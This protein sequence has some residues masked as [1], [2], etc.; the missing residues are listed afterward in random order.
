V[1]DRN[2][3]SMYIMSPAGKV[4]K[5]FGRNGPGPGE[6]VGAFF[7]Y[8][9][10]KEI[11]VIEGNGN[12]SAFNTDGTFIRRFRFGM[13]VSKGEPYRS[14][15][16]QNAMFVHNGWPKDVPPTAGKPN[17]SPV[18]VWVSA[19]DSSS[20]H[21]IA[22]VKGAERFEYGSM[23]LGHDTRLA[24]GN[25][26]VYVAEGETYE[27]KVFTLDG[28]PL[29]SITKSVKP[30]A[31]TK[32]DITDDIDRLLQMVG[33]SVAKKMRKQVEANYEAAPLPK[34]LPPYRELLVDIDQNLWVRDYA[35]SGTTNVIWTVF[36]RTGKQ[37][38]EL[39]LPNTL[40]VF[41]IGKDYVLGRYIEANADLPEVRMYQ[42]NRR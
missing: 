13:G 3:Y 33:P 32:Q 14:A 17:R 7:T 19:G 37:L 36:D 8:R 4:L 21:M 39:A 38:T 18:P 12:I 11:F 5:K 40:E 2:D 41:E 23:P 9:C 16:N 6:M 22:T 27:I 24:L 15:C 29:P 30:V 42:L 31:V 28:K 1:G 34:V 10:G 26:R 20:G 25:D 35:I